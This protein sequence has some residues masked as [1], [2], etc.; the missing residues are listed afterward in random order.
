MTRENLVLAT[1]LTGLLASQLQAANLGAVWHLDNGSG[2]T[3]SDSSGNG[4]T[5]C[6]PSI[7]N[8]STCFGGFGIGSSDNPGWASPAAA[9]FGASALVMDADDLVFVPSSASLSPA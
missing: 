9:K 6:F 1:C 5:G 4:N 3:I 8:I 7:V 2:T